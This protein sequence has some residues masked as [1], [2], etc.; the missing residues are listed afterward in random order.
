[1]IYIWATLLLI[2]GIFLFYPVKI[3]IEYIDGATKLTLKISPFIKYL[4]YDSE[5]SPSP[6]KKEKK[7]GGLKKKETSK[8]KSNSKDKAIKK[9]KSKPSYLLMDIVHTVLDVLPH[10]GRTIRLLLQG[11]T[12][13]HCNIGILL[14]HEDPYKLGMKCGKTQG[15]IH[16]LYPQLC[17]VVRMKHFKASVLPNF[18]GQQESTALEIEA[19]TTIWKLLVGIFYFI[20]HGGLKILK[21]PIFNKKENTSP[22]KA[23]NK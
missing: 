6:I 2:L 23:T 8:K 19:G 13:S 17:H 7:K 3:Y 18:L 22:K 10:F 4:L 16:S 12:I 1:M 15:V 11:I 14:Y 5:T 9:E 20:I 21:S